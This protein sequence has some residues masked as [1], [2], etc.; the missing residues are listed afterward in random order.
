M[1]NALFTLST[2]STADLLPGFAEANEIALVPLTFNVEK[3]G[4][5]SQYKDEFQNEEEYVAF[6]QNLRNGA[7]SRTAMLNLQT[8]TPATAIPLWIS[9]YLTE[10]PITAMCLSSTLKT[11]N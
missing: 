5:F 1:A 8:T 7:F 6:Y 11:A 9:R 10:W 2:D 3:N 4:D